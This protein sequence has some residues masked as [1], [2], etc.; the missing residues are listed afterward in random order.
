MEYITKITSNICIVLLVVIL[1][2]SNFSHA[3]ENQ[4]LNG[5]KPLRA[6]V[7]EVYLLNADDSADIYTQIIYTN[8]NNESLPFI[9]DFSFS[10]PI[11]NYSKDNVSNLTLF[12]LPGGPYFELVPYSTISFNNQH[13]YLEN[14]THF[15]KQT[16]SHNLIINIDFNSNT[17]EGN[18]VII[19]NIRYKYTNFSISNGQEKMILVPIN[20]FPMKN[21]TNINCTSY[22]LRVDIP[23]SPYTY[24]KFVSSNMKP[25]K[26]ESRGNGQSI[27]WDSKP[28]TDIILTFTVTENTISKK[29]D[30]MISET[31]Q[32][33]N[34]TKKYNDIVTI[35][36]V[37]S[38]LIT[39]LIIA[40]PWL[41]ENNSNN[42]G[43]RRRNKQ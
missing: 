16:Y 40:L 13:T 22:D 38:I 20:V 39:V 10:L 25:S 41:K 23:N 14:T 15:S 5:S 33:A 34:Q 31:N 21:L 11:R 32:Y 36:T 37:I 42:V 3:E 8:E 12:F 2:F 7:H 24:S 18:T 1:F 4:F 43:K 6:Q 27:Y 26:I 17:I 9:E 30:T 19:E 29:L 35:L 28:R